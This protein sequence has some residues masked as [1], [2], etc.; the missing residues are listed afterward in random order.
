MKKLYKAFQSITP[1]E[2]DNIKEQLKYR[3]EEVEV[4]M[5]TSQRKKNYKLLIAGLVCLMIVGLP[6][7]F[8]KENRVFATVG[9]DVNPSLELNIDTDKK[10]VDVNTINEDGQKILGDM[11]L[12]G[13]DVNVAMNALVGSM[14]KQGY[15]DELKNSLLISVAGASQEENEKLRQQLSE[16]IDRLLKGNQ[17]NGSIV[18][19]TLMDDDHIEELA[20]KYHI[21]QGKAEIIEDLIEKNPRYTFEELKDLS[22]NDLNILLSRND[23]DHVNVDGEVNTGAYLSKEKVK[24]IVE[25]DAK[26]SAVTYREIELD[27]EDGSMVYD[28]EFVKNNVE[29]DYELDAKT[30]KI[31]N[32]TKES[33]DKEEDDDLDEKPSTQMISQEKA[34]S[35]A[36]KHAQVTSVQNYHI[37]KDNDDGVWEYDIEFTNGQTK[38]EY[39]IRATDGKILSHEKESKPKAKIT[40]NQARDKA[41]QHAGYSLNQVQAL[42][43][44]LDEKGYYDVSFDVNG[45]EYDYEIDGN[46][47][48]VIHHDKE[49]N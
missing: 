37:D 11:D 17:I 19:Q 8:H 44:D 42:E 45:Y 4:Y 21:S 7:A 32:K 41:L 38:Y 46:T 2:F 47:G 34:K 13:S 33:V 24:Q 49:K 23:V 9:V 15:I 40:E 26:V 6:F 22:V 28:V 30:G 39:T 48:K 25:A 27:Y 10:V 43:V 20:I 36:M 31:L 12:E 1:N 16:D 29:Y 35:I 18:S 5:E 14:L 3:D